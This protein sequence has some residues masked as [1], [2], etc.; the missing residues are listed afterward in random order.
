MIVVPSGTCRRFGGE[1]GEAAFA[2]A[3]PIAVPQ[4]F[5][6]GKYPVT[7]A[8][9]EIVAGQ[10]NELHGLMVRNS[11]LFEKLPD[12]MHNRTPFQ[13]VTGEMAAKFCK[14]L[15]KLTQTKFTLP[16]EDEWEY[17]CRDGGDAPFPVGDPDRHPQRYFG[18]SNRALGY[19][20]AGTLS[21]TIPANQFGLIGMQAYLPEWCLMNSHS[22]SGPEYVLCGSSRNS[23]FGK[24]QPP[25][26]R[27]RG[28]P[29]GYDKSGGYG[30]RVKCDRPVA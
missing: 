21:G 25:W 27:Q 14:H 24:P 23:C 7:I 8:Q 1:G 20:D 26:H 12:S 18:S 28:A 10:D 13:G 22:D 4:P 15:S 30:F 29:H 19:C 16:S 11:Q 5:L 9:W 17:A 6:L 3:T 2:D